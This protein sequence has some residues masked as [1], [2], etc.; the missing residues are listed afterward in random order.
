MPTKKFALE[1][2]GPKRLE[3]SWTGMFKNVDVRLDGASIGVVPDRA[4]M[5]EG[6][7]FTLPDGSSLSLKLQ[8]SAYNPGLEVL[9]NGLPLPGS[10]ADPRT[11]V[12]VSAQLIYFIAALNALLGVAVVVFDVEALRAM[13]G[14]NGIGAFFM[15]A[16][17]SVLAFFT[18]GGSPWALI[19][20][21]LIYAAD[22]VLGVIDSVQAGGHV[23]TGGIVMRVIF[24]IFMSRGVRAAF[25]LKKARATATT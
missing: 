16:L 13:A 9:R 17:Y 5:K 10:D 14:P 3:L 21:M 11:Q 12:K 15:A 4:A 25:A 18:M 22:W 2:E 8:Q 19:A 24:L 20:A 23:N 7:V 1:D 6:R